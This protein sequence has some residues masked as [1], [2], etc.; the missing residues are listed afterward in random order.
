MSELLSQREKNDLIQALDEYLEVVYEEY[1]MSDTA[2]SYRQYMG[3]IAVLFYVFSGQDW[4]AVS[5]FQLTK[6]GKLID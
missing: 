6:E 5:G 3:R 2:A 4:Q 1:N